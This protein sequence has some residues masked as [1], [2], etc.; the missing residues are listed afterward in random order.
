MKNIIVFGPPGTG[1][2]TMAA[3]LSA[4]FGLRHIST[5]D[6]IRKNQEEK[7]KIGLLADKI[8]DGGGLLPDEI[9][10]EMIK[11]E[12]INDTTSGGFIFDGFPRTA[13]QARMLD[14]FLNYRKAPVSKVIYIETTKGVA[15]SRIIERGL[16]S[17]RKDDNRES[18]KERWS[19]YLS[20]T[21]PSLGYFESRG[22]VS[23]INGEQDIEEVYND[24]KKT[25]EDGSR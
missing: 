9:V 4:E 18:F 8:V 7:T 1:K 21:L 6:I 23:K 20:E 3:R 17:G 14:Q 11:Q 19:A 16:T 12:I 24:V 22:L 13:G 5:G 2:G 15:L 25:V 10:N